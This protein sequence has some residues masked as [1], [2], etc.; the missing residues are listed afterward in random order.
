MIIN[1]EGVDYETPMKFTAM[2]R[3]EMVNIMDVIESGNIKDDFICEDCG[4]ALFV[5]SY[6]RE[7]KNQPHFSHYPG[8]SCVKRDKPPE[9][10]CPRGFTTHSLELRG[11]R[12]EKYMHYLR[13]LGYV[14][15][16]L[17]DDRSNE[18]LDNKGE[19]IWTFE[20]LYYDDKVFVYNHLT[21]S[22]CIPA[23]LKSEL[24]NIIN[25][26][27]LKY[28][29]DSFPAYNFTYDD[30]YI[31]ASYCGYAK[32][33]YKFKTNAVIFVKLHNKFE[34]IAHKVKTEL[35]NIKIK[36]EIQAVKDAVARY[37]KEEYLDNISISRF[38]SFF[39][40][41]IK[42]KSAD[43]ELKEYVYGISA[44]KLDPLV[45]NFIA[46]IE[47]TL[48]AKEDKE[49][50]IAG[51]QE[52]LKANFDESYGCYTSKNNE[53]F[54]KDCDISSEE[55]SLGIHYLNK[56]SPKPHYE[57]FS[58]G[59][60][61]FKNCRMD[62]ENRLSPGSNEIVLEFKKT[63][64][65]LKKAT[66]ADI[67]PAKSRYRVLY[68]DSYN[69]PHYLFEAGNKSG[70]LVRIS[71]SD[72]VNS[73][74]IF[75]RL[76]DLLHD[77][78]SAYTRCDPKAIYYKRSNTDDKYEPFKGFLNIKDFFLPKYSNLDWSDEAKSY[79]LVP[80][81]KTTNEFFKSHNKTQL[82]K[83]TDRSII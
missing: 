51:F 29:H 77:E 3:G 72:E 13:Q 7:N 22:R 9:Y 2:L 17:R 18:A 8:E 74:Y 55:V 62:R 61:D 11:E 36:G 39:P 58:Y 45:K 27:V 67:Y 48:F 38:E 73:Y 82:F 65:E 78:E 57:L 30:V 23:D 40:I 28:L 60:S 19:F 63:C 26:E 44:D 68:T 69:I 4:K 70:D 10:F 41:V 75:W 32:S 64:K 5:K 80:E 15:S 52:F 16:R 59:S 14:F 53:W 50:I 24:V 12:L 71:C 25:N 42:Y 35:P 31:M 21:N 6:R 37:A 83:E 47:S 76:E 34:E 56:R 20:R 43:N 1:F 66:L 33:V 49:K 54:L 81:L 46:E 79:N